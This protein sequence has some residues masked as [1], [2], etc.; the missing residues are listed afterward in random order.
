MPPLGGTGAVMGAAMSAAVGAPPAGG[1]FFSAI[2]SVIASWGLTNIRVL[3]GT[4]VSAGTAVSGQGTI[5]VDDNHQDLGLQLATAVGNPDDPGNVEEWTEIA[6]GI[7]GHL[8]IFAKVDGST[9]VAPSPGPGPLTGTAKVTMT[10]YLF[11]P[12][13]A[14]RLDLVDPANLA[15][16][17]SFELSLNQHIVSNATA[18]PISIQAPFT[19]LTSPGGGGPITGQGSIT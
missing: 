18:V 6:K 7:I 5:T 14:V 2:G 4:M 10:G 15:A 13:L 1:A 12:P 8:P 17:S 16:M 9:F 19:P 3:P 11:V